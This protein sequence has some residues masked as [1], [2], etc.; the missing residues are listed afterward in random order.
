MTALK[1]T[2][3]NESRSEGP[4]SDEDFD[5]VLLDT[6]ERVGRIFAKLATGGG[7]RWFWGLGFPHTLNSRQPYYG[8]VESKDAAKQAF[9][10]GWRSRH[11]TL[12]SKC[13]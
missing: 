4:W 7:T 13:R 1:L 2:P 8:T 12:V 5:V 9:A 11:S 10:E 3:A 6:G